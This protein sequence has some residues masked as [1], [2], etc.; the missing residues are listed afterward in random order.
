MEATVDE[1][2]GID[3]ATYA[4]RWTILGVLCL[5]LLVVMIANTSMNVALPI[6]SRD[7]GAS[8]SQ[9][10]WLVDAYSLVFAGLL[11]TA[12]AMG[13]RFGRKGILQLGLLVF[14]LSAA[15]AAIFVDSPTQ[16]IV[17]R[18]VMGLGGALVMPATLSILTNVFPREE[19]A[20]AVGLWAGISGGGTA[21]GPVLTGFLL[22]NFSWHAVFAINIPFVVIA[23][24]GV[25]RLVPRSSNPHHDPI[26]VVGAV[27]S[28]VSLTS[29]VYALIE[30]PQ[31]GWL[32]PATLL[33]AGGGL[34]VMAIFALWEL[35]A[36]H[37]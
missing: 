8:Q 13:D 27:L 29:V 35:R 30:A 15:A 19:R 9:L 26:D 28:A 23:M 37:P 22:E 3:P 36:E 24:I 2:H 11:F 21:I 14:A 7:L 34:V 18:A 17:V 10:Q 4:R 33:I 12:G 31:N 1:E 6:L 25:S 20:R 16:L 32:S 5:C